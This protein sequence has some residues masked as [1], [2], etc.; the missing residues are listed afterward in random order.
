MVDEVIAVRSRI[1]DDSG[2]NG[3]T[4]FEYIVLQA[5]GI[6]AARDYNSKSKIKIL[7]VKFS[8]SGG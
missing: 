4:N 3:G 8:L 5:T 7:F 2:R 1:D 6:I